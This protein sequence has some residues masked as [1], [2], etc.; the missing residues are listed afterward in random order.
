MSA[1]LLILVCSIEIFNKLANSL[2]T[3]KTTSYHNEYRYISK[4][5]KHTKKWA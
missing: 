3:N 1:F 4:P 5:L 2:K